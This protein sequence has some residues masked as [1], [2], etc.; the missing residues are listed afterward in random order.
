VQNKK[1]SKMQAI[2]TVSAGPYNF[3]V[4]NDNRPFGNNFVVQ[5]ANVTK[6]N[7]QD[8]IACVVLCTKDSKEPGRLYS[9][10]YSTQGRLQECCTLN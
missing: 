4:T 7:G 1:G 5:R 2:N 10:Q 9:V 3:V 6:Y 8:E